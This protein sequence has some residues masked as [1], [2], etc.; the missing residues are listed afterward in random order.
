MTRMQQISLL[1]ALTPPTVLFASS[2]PQTILPDNVITCQPNANC[3]SKKLYG[4]NYKVI[5]SPRFTVMI[6]V[7][8]EG[9]YTRAD[10]SIANNTVLPQNVTPEDFRVEVITPKPKVLLYVPPS[11]LK[12]LPSSAPAP[13]PPTS[14]TPQ[15]GSS[16][17]PHQTAPLIGAGALQAPDVDQS[18][19]E[20][21]TKAAEQV[22]SDHPLEA[23]S[24]SPNEVA[25]GRVYFERVKHEQ[26]VNVVLPI[27]GLVFEFP[28]NMR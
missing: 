22:A 25:R 5:N 27:A 12:D 10:V 1:V 14:P 13:P 6:S 15:L 2:V 21:K 7:S 28:Y 26:L 18:D 20:A 11:D 8:Q 17:L 3:F 16:L 4:R 23:T 24:L 9:P 19:P